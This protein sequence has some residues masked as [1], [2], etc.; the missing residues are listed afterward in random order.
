VFPFLL[1]LVPNEEWE[2]NLTLVHACEKCRYA[3]DALLDA[4]ERMVY[5]VLE[6]DTGRYSKHSSPAALYVTRLCL[7][8]YGYALTLLH[9]AEWVQ[10]SDSATTMSGGG[11]HVRGLECPS[12]LS[13]KLEQV[14]T[15]WRSMLLGRILPMLTGWLR[16]CDEA[17]DMDVVCVLRAHLAY[18]FKETEWTVAPETNEVCFIHLFEKQFKV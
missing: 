8:V 18:I 4:I 1:P 7:R 13:T 14:T 10:K 5:N 2:E 3:P 17:G 12:A 9:H 11:T 16:R 6:L 15:R